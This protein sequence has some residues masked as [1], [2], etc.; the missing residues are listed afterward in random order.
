MRTTSKHNFTHYTHPSDISKEELDALPRATFTGRI[1]V[2]DTPSKVQSAVQALRSSDTLGLDTETK[3]TFVPGKKRPVA[4]LQI[5]T[6]DT[7]F[8]FRLNKIGLPRELCELLED[9]DILKIGLSLHDDL[10]GLRRVNP[11][12]PAGFVELQQLAP[13]YGLR[14]AS[15]QKLYGLLCG[16]YMSK[17]QRMTNWEASVLTEQQQHYA[18]LDAVASLEVYN[19]LMS[20][21]APAPAQF[22]V[23]YL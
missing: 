19:H 11:F 21:P 3:P 22:G 6:L 5:A 16:G 1:V 13:A 15:L 18:A 17:S 20:L 23:V 8:L 7:C 9:P 12:E 14:C 4:L 2:I 10:V